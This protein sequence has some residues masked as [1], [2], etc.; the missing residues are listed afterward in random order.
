M[1]RRRLDRAQ[2]MR[3][4]RIWWER[5]GAFVRGALTGSLLTALVAWLLQSLI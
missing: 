3:A 4:R 5:H 2:R 1:Q